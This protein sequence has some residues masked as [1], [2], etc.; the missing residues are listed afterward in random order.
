MRITDPEKIDAALRLMPQLYLPEY[1]PEGW[2]M[3][4]LEVTKKTDG[5]CTAGFLYENG[6]KQS[7]TIEE[8]DGPD[9]RTVVY[10]KTF[11]FKNR[12]LNFGN[13]IH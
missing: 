6:Q 2:E 7:M 12:T 9:P 11:Y 4:S 5:S 1:L 8:Y 10:G 13:I 3:K